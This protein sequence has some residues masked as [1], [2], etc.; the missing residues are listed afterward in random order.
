M[1]GPTKKIRFG[2]RFLKVFIQKHWPSILLGIVGGSLLFFFFPRLIH[3]LSIERDQRIGL[4]GRFTATELPLEVQKLA[5]DGLTNILPSGQATPSLA[6]SWRIKENGREYLFNLRDDIYWQNQKPVIAEDINY[7]FNDVATEVVDQK[8][9]KFTL[10]EPYTPFPN[11]VSRPI[12]K[13]GFLGTGEYKVKSVRKNG[14]IIEK[15]VFVPA[16]DKSKPKIIYRF[17]PT[18]DAARQG[19]LIS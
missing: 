1:K 3:F 17:Y 9:I 7:N 4:V 14:Q 15:I 13:K 16:V 11:V 19:K 6:G 12:F 10:K 2:L 18:E 5:S 8:T